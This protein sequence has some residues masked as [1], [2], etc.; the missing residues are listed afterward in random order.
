MTIPRRSVHAAA[1]LAAAVLAAACGGAPSSAGTASAPEKVIIGK[2]VD[3][4]GFTTVDVALKEGFF[5]Q[6]GVDVTEKLLGGSTQAN[7]ALQGGSIQFTTASSLALMLARAQGVPLI[8]I[9]SL[10]FGVPLQLV[11]ANS[12]LKDHNLG[13]GMPLDQRMRGLQGSKFAN[14]GSTDKGFMD[15][16]LKQAGMSPTSVSMISMQS[17][18]DAVA[19]LSH[20]S[21]TE[22]LAAPPSSIAAADQGFATVLLNGREIQAWRDMTYD[23]LI[24]SE[25]FARKDPAAVR[26]VATAMAEADNFIA[27]HPDR[28]LAIEQQHFP[29]YSAAVLR[30]SLQLVTFAKN[31]LQTA[32][33]WSDAADVFQGTG[34]LK[35]KVQP[36]EGVDWTNQYIDV[37]RLKS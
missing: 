35:Q 8:S 12:W 36:A 7:A 16:L 10:D 19:A 26:K 33:G 6:Q 29:S 4:I 20:G 21:V 34:L 22:F 1:V 18:A 15:L 37:S 17:Q 32:A 28:A 3:T 14:I 24:T 31:G 11:V 5:K 9:T 2:A 25:D 30:Q 13:P 27:A 23:I